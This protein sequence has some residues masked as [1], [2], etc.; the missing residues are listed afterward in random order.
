MIL[1]K[2]FITFFEIGIL[3]FG[4]GYAMI[5][6]ITQKVLENNWMSQKELIDF[7]AVS[8]STPGPFAVNIATFIGEQNGGFFGGLCAVLGVIL[9]SFIVILFVAKL[10]MKFCESRAVKGAMTGIRPAVIGLLAFTVIS[11]AGGVLFGDGITAA[12]FAQP[13]FI[14]SLAVIIAMAVLA[15]K[16]VNS[17]LII[18]ISAALGIAYGYIS[19][20]LIS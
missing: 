16:K 12:R 7:V 17:I 5:P 14:F 13:A 19:G 20:G 8:E 18:G 1:F 4:G 10:Y 3:T 2:L 9:P 15:F 11:M 6:M